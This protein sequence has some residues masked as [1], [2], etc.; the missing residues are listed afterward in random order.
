VSRD[1]QQRLDPLGSLAAWPLSAVIGAF[2]LC[3]AVISTVLQVDQIHNPMLA[4]LAVVMMTAAAGTLLYATKPSHSPFRA[5][6]HLVMLAFAL[7]AYLFEQLSRWGSNL[8][9]QDDFGPISIGLLLLGLAPYR[10]WR[11]IVL[12]GGIASVIAIALTVPQA[13][14]FRVDVPVAVF[15]IVAVTQILAPAAAGAAYSRRV[16]KSVLSWQADARRAIVGRTEEARGQMARAVV[17]QQVTE[18]EAGVI[19]FLTEVLARGSITPQDVAQAGQLAG[20]VR[21]SLVAEIDRT[22][23]DAL[24]TRERAGLAERGTAGL[25][26]VADPE[27]RAT[28]FRADQRAA[29]AALIG[30]LCAAPGFDP[31]SLVVQITGTGPT[32]PTAAPKRPATAAQQLMQMTGPIIGKPTP[33]PL[34]APRVDTITIQ[35]AL[36]M[37]KL[38]LRTLLRPYL[39]VIRVV[40][41]NIRVDMRRP[42]LT[43]EFDSTQSF[44]PTDPRL[45]GPATPARVRA[46]KAPRQIR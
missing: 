11:E 10:P 34:V 8:L 43:I 4:T 30:A 16:V 19:P 2:V 21:R 6:L 14:H 42:S 9:V 40:F 41:E 20:E 29:T 23:L 22:W 33:P 24:V 25:L 31:H 38:K 26:V 28:A 5:H 18:L 1:T 15:A 35:V 39:G 27:H 17:E 12:S 46:A 36:D 45:V 37:P 7:L 32:R 13:E 3:F 44:D